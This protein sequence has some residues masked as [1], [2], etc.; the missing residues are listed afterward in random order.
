MMLSMS[1]A[2]HSSR[3]LPSTTR[4]MVIPLETILLPVAGIP[5]PEPVLVP[6]ARHNPGRPREGA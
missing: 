3:I 2:L 5:L 1:N 4:Q 6:S